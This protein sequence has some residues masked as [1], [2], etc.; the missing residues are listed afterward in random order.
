MVSHARSQKDVEAAVLNAWSRDY[1]V[2][3]C[4]Y[5]KIEDEIR[6]VILTGSVRLSYRKKRL[7]LQGDGK[8]SVEELLREQIST[9]SRKSRSYAKALS[10]MTVEQL[11]SVPAID[12]EFPVEWRHNLGL[13]ACAEIVDSQEAAILGIRAAKALNMQ[14]C[15]VD[16]AKLKDGTFAVLEVNSG[17][18]MD[19]FICSSAV[20]R[21][22]AKDI[23]T[24]VIKLSLGA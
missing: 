14:F 18:M 10:S 9:N 6:V 22:I 16:V 12:E 15:S 19:S 3:V 4:P 1:G 13:G 2:A 20:N 23:Y 5:Y 7:S 17:V 21:A 24:Q 8:R 11:Q